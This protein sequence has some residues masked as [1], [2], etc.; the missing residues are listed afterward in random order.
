MLRRMMASLLKSRTGPQ[1]LSKASVGFDT[2]HRNPK[3][4]NL[5]GDTASGV[6]L[7]QCQRGLGIDGLFKAGPDACWWSRA[8][9]ATALMREL[10]ILKLGPARIGSGLQAWNGHARHGYARHGH[11]RHGHAHAR[12]VGTRPAASSATCCIYLSAAVRCCLACGGASAAP[13]G[14][15][16][17]DELEDEML[18]ASSPPCFQVLSKRHLRE[19]SVKIFS[20]LLDGRNW[21]L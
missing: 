16:C 5:V 11:A 8:C 2:R 13:D 20:L 1:I 19:S 18:P 12:L 7:I 10:D 14:L 15:P 9:R 3:T 6:A 17:S 21:I 4:C